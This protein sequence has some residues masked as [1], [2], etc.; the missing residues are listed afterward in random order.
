[1]KRIIFFLGMLTVFGLAYGKPIDENTAKY[2]GQSFLKFE[3]FKVGKLESLSTNNLQLVYK[4]N[5]NLSNPSTSLRVTETLFYVFNIGENG[6]VIVSGDDNVTPILAYSDEVSFN[7]NNIPPTVAKWLDKYKDE[8]RY[9][10]ENNVQPTNEI[11]TKWNYL[12]THPFIPSQKGNSVASTEAVNPLVKTKWDQSPYYND[13][14]P[15]DNQYND[16]TVTGCVATAMAQIMKFWNYPVNGEGFHSYDNPNYGTLS[17]NFGSTT[18]Q[19]N[20]MPNSIASANEA[21]ATLMYQ[22]GVSVDMNYGV[23]ATGGSSGYVIS[24]QSPVTNCSEYALKTYFGYK[25]TL[26]GLER[27]KYDD[28]AWINLLKTELNAGRPVLYD[29]FGNGGGHCF[30]ADGY[31]NNDFIHFNWGWSGAFDGFFQINALNP[32]GTGTGGGTGGFNFGQQAVIGI[33]PPS[34]QNQTYK[35]ALYNYVTPSA[36]TLNYGQ[37]FTITTNIVNAGTNTFAGD[38]CAAVFDDSYTFV[39]YVE[40]KTGATLQGGYAYNNDLVFS[41]TGLLSMLPGTYYVI[42]FYRP[43]GG[44]WVQI[45]DNAG[46]TNVAQINVVFANDIELYSAIT[47]TPGTTLT[48]GQPASVNLNII[49]NNGT[50]TFIGQYGVALYDLEGTLVQTIAIVDETNGLPP[51][52]TYQSPYVTFA[53]QSITAGPGTYLLALLFNYNNTGWQLAGSTF[54]QNPIKVTVQ[55]A[56][57]KPDKYEPNNTVQTAYSLPIS[58]TGNTTDVNTT[59]SNCH[60]GADYDFYK[61]VFPKGYNYTVTPKLF[62]LYNNDNN[63][64]TLAALTSFSNDATNWSDAYDDLLSI[65]LTLKGGETLYVIVA[66]YFSG[67]TGT[68]L[69]D[70]NI[71]RSKADA[72]EETTTSDLINLYPNPA[73]DFVTVDLSGFSQQVSKIEVLNLQGQKMYSVN[74]EEGQKTLNLPLENYSKG[75]YLLQLYTKNGIVNKK[76][77]GGK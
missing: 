23:G 22:V 43:T 41:S 66:P 34:N 65:N 64:Y 30:V 31:D 6:Y 18:Y 33:E 36:N 58:F 28:A 8:I 35:I 56:E 68:Y 9:I 46:Y 10:I 61:I 17:A 70:M 19:W 57:L 27:S 51:G 2:V 47:V 12:N 73:E 29:G 77:I 76:I 3:S 45:E 16:R 20:S 52:Y 21:I 40:I 11:S 37:A 13:L 26:Q 7:P 74:I 50:T 60:T 75:L 53:T 67:S 38:Y 42:M 5:S 54:N 59:G 25:T 24:S 71:T 39:D 63:K 32:S 72:V 49:N 62:D 1:M 14:C 44:N 69:L 55:E 4:A 15:Y 48:N